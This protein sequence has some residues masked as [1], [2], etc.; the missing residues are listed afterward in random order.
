MKITQRASIFQE[1]LHLGVLCPTCHRNN[2]QEDLELMANLFLA[3][4]GYFG[5]KKKD[6]FDLI[7]ILRELVNEIHTVDS[8]K[9]IENINVKL[10][11]Q[12]LLHGISP[13]EYIEI[14]QDILER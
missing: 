9:S 3:F 4:G 13:L 8:H 6:K 2:T 14:L 12:A 10:L 5:M 7:T 11:H 1:N